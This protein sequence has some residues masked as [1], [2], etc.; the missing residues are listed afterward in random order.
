M[1]TQEAMLLLSQAL[2]GVPAKN[3]EELLSK[4]EAVGAKDRKDRLG[5]ILKDIRYEIST[6]SSFQVLKEYAKTTL[7]H[8]PTK[9]LEITTVESV[10]AEQASW[11]VRMAE[12]EGTFFTDRIDHVYGVEGTVGR[13]VSAAF[14]INAV[15]YVWANEM[16]R[17]VVEVNVPRHTI[18]A[19]VPFPAV[20]FTFK[21]A[22]TMNLDQ[23]Y[24]QSKETYAD[25]ILVIQLAD[26]LR[27]AVVG[28]NT[29][30]RLPF[31][32]LMDVFQGAIFPDEVPPVCRQTAQYVLSCLS[33][34]NSPFI[35]LEK[36][37]MCRQARRRIGIPTVAAESNAVRFITL[38]SPLYKRDHQESHSDVDWKFRWLVRGHHRAQWCPST[39]DHKLMWIAPY[40]KGP[41]GLPMKTAAYKVV[42]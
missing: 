40:V 13:Q 32:L 38:R 41:E 9:P 29:D 5:K 20:W 21:N 16:F 18:Q 6:H 26:R 25:G 2:A 27:I 7:Q 23:C 12:D 33:F 11:A 42:R 34:I 15:P 39:R 22:V 37:M 10:I 24:K 30:S 17:L 8:D 1:N 14:M 4:L 36:R 19:R 3:K 28:T 35:V 31:C